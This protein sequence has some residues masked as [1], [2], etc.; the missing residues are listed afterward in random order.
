M[1]P[2]DRNRRAFDEAH[3]S[4]ENVIPREGIPGPIRERLR[5]LTGQRV[6]HLGCGAGIETIELSQLGALVTGVDP[7]ERLVEEAKDRLRMMRRRAE[8]GT[9]TSISI[10]LRTADRI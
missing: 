2:T 10:C 7:E 5:D 9:M 1:E 4:S 8:H 3:K 6:V